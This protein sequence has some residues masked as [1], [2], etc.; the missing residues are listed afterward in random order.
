MS[1]FNPEV[2][3]TKIRLRIPSGY[4]PVERLTDTCEFESRR[5]HVKICSVCDENKSLNEYSTRSSRCKPCHRD[6]TRNHYRNN[7]QYYV[8]KAA[9]RDK[10]VRKLNQQNLIDFLKDHPCV[11]C[12]N[13]DL[14][15]LE[16]DHVDPSEKLYNVSIMLSFPWKT[17]QSEIDKCLVRCSNCHTKKTRRQFGWWMR[18]T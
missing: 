16:F 14:E 3:Y 13:N 10:V 2:A 12:G 11:D 9:A 8:D 7:K 6:Y 5:G 4:E 18:D 17:I 1:R 15:V